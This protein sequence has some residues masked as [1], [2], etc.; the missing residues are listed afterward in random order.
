MSMTEKGK[1]QH[2]HKVELIAAN[3]LKSAG[4][5]DSLSL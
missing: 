4:S 2:A 3:A 5:K 1:T